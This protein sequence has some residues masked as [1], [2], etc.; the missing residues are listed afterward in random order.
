MEI[1]QLAN[2]VTKA[3]AYT[4]NGGKPNISNP[5]AGKTGEMKSIFQYTPDTWK[6]VSKQYFGKEVPLT[7]DNETYATQQRVKSWLQQGKT[8]SQIASM[9]NAGE[10]EPDA[11]SGKFSTGKSSVGTNAK[12]GVGYD[13]PDYAKKVLA[14]SKEFYQGGSQSQNPAPQQ[15]DAAS[16]LMSIVQG[17][18]GQ[19]QS[20]QPQQ[21]QGKSLVSLPSS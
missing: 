16:S 19:K 3:L 12:Y 20:S 15:N 11:Y 10:G 13:V 8:V 17:A 6:S 2:A 4:E 5:S 7:A 21:Q 14:Y 18:A 1:D 9:H